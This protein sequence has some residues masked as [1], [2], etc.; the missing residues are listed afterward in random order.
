MLRGRYLVDD[1]VERAGAASLLAPAVGTAALAPDA[2]AEAGAFATTS[3][4][5]AEALGG[6]AGTLM[7]GSFAAPAGV[8]ARAESRSRGAS[9]VV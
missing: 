9:A 2:S 6:A 7:R 4:A 3:V 8:V 5:G 1:G